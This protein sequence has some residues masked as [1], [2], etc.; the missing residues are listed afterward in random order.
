[1]FVFRSILFNVLAFWLCVVFHL[2]NS[3][4]RKMLAFKSTHTYT[5]HGRRINGKRD[6]VD[7]KERI[8]LDSAKNSERASERGK[9]KAP[10][11]SRRARW[12]K[13]EGKRLRERQNKNHIDSTNFRWHCICSTA[14]MEHDCL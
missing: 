10:K 8:R 11:M 12:E 3:A 9:E 13:R 4:K 1:M 2:D 14:L 6:K 7:G 5:K